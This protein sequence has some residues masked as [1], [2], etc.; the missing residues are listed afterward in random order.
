MATNYRAAMNDRDLDRAMASFV[1]VWAR[2]EG[3][4]ARLP[5]PVKRMMLLGSGRLYYEWLGPWLDEP[6]RSDLAELDIPTL[7]INGSNTIDSMHRVCEISSQSLPNCRHVEIDGAGHMSPFTHA[8][9][10]LP[11]V[12][13]HLA[14]A[15]S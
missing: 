2:N 10:V 3:T 9:D 4:W 11:A 13:A 12:R 1:D 8:E 15:K 14:S 5:D 6:S 7:L